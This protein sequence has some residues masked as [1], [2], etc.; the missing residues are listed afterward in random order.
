VHVYGLVARVALSRP[1]FGFRVEHDLPPG[2]VLVEARPRATVVGDHLI[3][4]IGRVDPGQKL[5]LEVIVRLLPGTTLQADD[6]ATF[7]ATYSQNLFFEVPVVR[8]RLTARMSG[9]ATANVGE[10]VEYV[11]DV[12]SSGSAPVE[13]AIATITL[14]PTLAHREGPTL[15]FPIGKLRPGEFR[16]LSAP[17]LVVASGTAI[18]RAV[19][20]GPADR[21]ANVEIATQLAAAN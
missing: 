7:T 4:Q 21:Q 14:P 5:R 16:R 2:V 3:W 17:A 15:T 6:L 10:V 12:A 1:A 11:L 13:D 8:P 9:P 18:V 20:V 19:V